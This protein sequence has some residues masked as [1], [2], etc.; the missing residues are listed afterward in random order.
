V[1]VHVLHFAANQYKARRLRKFAGSEKH[2]PH[3]RFLFSQDYST[4]NIYCSPG[5][6]RRSYVAKINPSAADMNVRARA[7]NMHDAG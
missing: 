6:K 5:D 7:A 2:A 3:T 1:P 4:V